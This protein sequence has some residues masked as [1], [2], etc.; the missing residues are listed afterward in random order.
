MTRSRNSTTSSA[1]ALDLE[2]GR[3]GVGAAVGVLPR[4]SHPGQRQVLDQVGPAP[5]RQ[6]LVRPARP[7][8]EV[9]AQRSGRPAPGDGHPV[10]LGPADDGLP[11]AGRRPRRLRCSQHVTVGEHAGAGAGGPGRLAPSTARRFP[12]TGDSPCEGALGWVASD[13]A[14]TSGDGG[15]AGRG[16]STGRRAPRPP[17]RRRRRRHAARRARGRPARDDPRRQQR[18]LPAGR[19]LA[20]LARR[21]ARARPVRPAGPPPGL[22]RDRR[23]RHGPGARRVHLP[24]AEHHRRRALGPAGLADGPPRGGRALHRSPSSTTSRWR[25]RPRWSATSCSPRSR[26]SAPSSP[27]PWTPAPTASPSSPPTGTPTARSSTRSSS[28]STRPAPG[29]S[30]VH[31][32]AG[33]SVRDFFPEAGG[34]RPARGDPR[35]LPHPADPAAG[36][37]GRLR[38]ALGGRA[39]QRH[40]PHRRRP[41]PV[42]VPRHHPRPPR[43]DAP[44]ARRDPR[45]PDRP[46]QP[47]P[48]ARPDR[49]R[50][51][52]GGP[53]R[54]RRDHRLPR[55][56]RL[57]DDQR[58][59]R[60]HL[61]RR[62]AAPGVGAPDPQRARRG[63]RRP[64]R[65]R[66]VRPRA[67]GL[68]ATSGSGC[69]CTAG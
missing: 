61:R 41:G 57:Q 54:R 45:R 27:P 5:G 56:R 1:V 53:R 69:T 63:H 20:G 34:D 13:H 42:H 65:R 16:T 4:P 25:R 11:R 28:G 44:A 12:R 19:A 59:P 24:P 23:A 32:L 33:R 39:R 22:R 51:A 2:G 7:Q 64:A 26:P 29:D 17:G 15:G 38:P 18:L 62:G 37:R 58:H 48:A 60:A 47:G 35:D 31:E 3:R 43:R 68:R 36:R 55:P 10:H 67:R 49:A 40:R 14:T 21:R 6:G 50:P 30:H 9:G 8:G 52:P 66:R 46:A